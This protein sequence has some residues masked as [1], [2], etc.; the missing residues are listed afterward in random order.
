MATNEDAKKAFDRLQQMA[1]ASTI[2][3]TARI[4]GHTSCWAPMTG[5]QYEQVNK[6]IDKDMI[7]SVW[8]SVTDKHIKKGRLKTTSCN[9][10]EI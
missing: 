1:S 8:P 3:E 2:N 9:V 6:D 10:P 5:A 4:A 7:K